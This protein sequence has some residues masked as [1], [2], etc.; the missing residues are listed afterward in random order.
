MA[1]LPG[2]LQESLALRYHIDREVGGGGMVAVFLAED[3][4][5]HGRVA[6]KVLRP[7]LAAETG[8]ERFVRKT[9]TAAGSNHPHI[10]RLLRPLFHV[11]WPD[12]ARYAV[13]VV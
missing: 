1:D 8:P 13:G 5:H 2:G 7:E 9:E 4:R 11:E 12:S 3:L 6:L 10:L